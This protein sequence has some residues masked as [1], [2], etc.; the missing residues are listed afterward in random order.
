MH[1][2]YNHRMEMVGDDEYIIIIVLL[3]GVIIIVIHKILTV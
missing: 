1:E 2:L 3:Y